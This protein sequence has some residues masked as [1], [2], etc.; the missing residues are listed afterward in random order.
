MH[1]NRRSNLP[2]ADPAEELAHI[3]ANLQDT[4]YRTDGDG[5]LVRVSAAV[6]DML[7]YE[8]DEVIGRKLAEFY[9]EP[10]GHAR[11]LA[12]LNAAG[13][14]IKGYEI[15]L[16]HRDGSTVWVAVNAQ[17]LRDARGEPAGVEGVVRDNTAARAA[18]AHMRTL[19]SAL[20]QTA[21]MVM[22]ADRGGVVE[23]VNQAF[24][25]ISGYGPD[26]VIG[27]RPNV[28]KSGR[29]GAEFYARLW[30]TILSGEV[31]HDVLINRRKDG[32]FYYEEK[33]ITPLKDAEG[34]ITHFIATGRDISERMQTQ[35]RLQYLAYHDVLTKL[36]NRALLMERLEH[37]ATRA[38][39][40][41]N[42]L[43]L[44]FLDLDRFKVIN[45]TL[46]HDFGDRLL[47]VLAH[48][49]LQCVRQEDTVAR[50]S[51]DEFA[52][53]IESMES[54]EA[55]A[56][57]ARKVLGVFV[58]P[59]EVFDRELFV[60]TSIGVS[61]FPTDGDNGKTL[62]KHADTAMYRAK[63]KG[64]NTFQF[65]SA[66]MSAAALDRLTLETNLRRA[67]ERDEFVLHYQPQ[68]NLK[69]G[70]VIGV[71]ALLRWVH[72][73]RGLL[74]A[75]SFIPLLEETGLITPVGEWVVKTACR[76]IG[77]LQESHGLP[78]RLAINLSPR[79][80]DSLDLIER[81][82][83]ATRDCRLPPEQLEFEITE[84]LLMSRTA[85]TL[86]TLSR[87]ADFGY[88]FAIDDFGTGYSSLSY[89]K[90]FPISTLKVDRS[91]VRDMPGDKD[92]TA[93]VNTIVAM[94]RSLDLEV[95]AEGVETDEQLAALRAFGC[96][97][98]QGFLYSHP[99]PL[100]ELRGF[101]GAH[102]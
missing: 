47:Q 55:V 78:L 11:F 97:N 34:R 42:R 20:E 54:A 99:L 81:I 56:E 4:Y 30:T 15:A 1:N 68:F 62:L 80:F 7:G 74:G 53:L 29:Q 45:D 31:F 82:G 93:I 59:F 17:L 10:E 50:L 13:G 77:Q 38:R 27:K 40:R 102:G 73:E 22:I 37:A 44:L 33:T 84:S 57:V 64:R 75:P 65:Y 12:A 71:E 76:E 39:R 83:D 35:E 16:R 87:L 21:D 58:Q 6:K 63:D 49:L 67:L 43:A 52:I 26:E 91:F 19:S 86:D 46:G 89:L 90:R 9:V 41:K 70:R 88:R 36:P 25:D 69:T 79:Q 72:P 23:Y 2:G 61:I 96:D 92:D 14:S 51:G 32:T 48:R 24:C 101:L 60:T 8:P 100:A 28:M 98:F 18:Q 95:T 66:E 5:R 94:A 3:L 85:G